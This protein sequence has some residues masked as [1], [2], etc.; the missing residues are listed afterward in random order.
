MISFNLEFHSLRTSPLTTWMKTKTV[1]SSPVYFN[2]NSSRGMCLWTNKMTFSKLIFRRVTKRT[3]SRGGQSLP[4][5]SRIITSSMMRLP[6]PM[7][8]RE[9]SRLMT[10]AANP[11]PR[12]SITNWEDKTME[13]ETPLSP[14]SSCNSWLLI[15]LMSHKIVSS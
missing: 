12:S 7:I 8:R 4:W 15:N 5:I 10:T 3:I 13:W 11:K 1:L 6:M 14:S 9:E 2:R